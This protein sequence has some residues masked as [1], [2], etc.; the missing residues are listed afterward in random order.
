V[1]LG[2]IAHHGI[3]NGFETSGRHGRDA[4]LVRGSVIGEREG[5]QVDAF[6]GLEPGLGLVSQ[7]FPAGVRMPGQGHA[8]RERQQQ[9][10]RDP[11]RPAS[12]RSCRL[13]P[14]GDACCGEHGV[15]LHGDVARHHT[16]LRCAVQGESRLCPHH[17][18]RFPVSAAWSSPLLA[19][20]GRK[21]MSWRPGLPS[22]SRNARAGGLLLHPIPVASRGADARASRLY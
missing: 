22:C 7:E 10:A 11:G 19:Q 8:R 18:P 2:L 4:G 6:D 5:F 12:S 3:A 14:M 21:T 17:H 1:R 15:G 20:H 16:N 9:D 13:F